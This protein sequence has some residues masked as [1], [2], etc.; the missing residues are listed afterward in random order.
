M[1]LLRNIFIVISVC[2]VAGAARGAE[3]SFTGSAFPA[4]SVGAEASTGLDGV[5][6]LNGLTGVSATFTASSAS[7]A[8]S[9]Q[10]WGNRGAAYAEDVDPALISR[11]GRRVTLSRLSADTGYTVTD[12]NRS[13]YFWVADYTAHPFDITALTPEPEQDCDRTIIRTTGSA[14]RMIY[15]SVTA[16]SYTIDRGITVS[17]STLQPD[18]DNM[19]FT[20]TAA[21]VSL[22][23]VDGT[24]NVEAPLCDTY[25][26][27][28]GDRFL[29]AWG[30][31]QEISSERFLTQAVDAIVKVEQKKRESDN[32]IKTE[33]TLGGSAPAD[34][35]FAAAVTDAAIFTQWQM[36]TDPDFIDIFYQSPDTELTYTFTEMGTTYV[37]FTCANATGTCDYFS[38]TYTVYIGESRLQC[39]N[40]FSPGP[41]EGVNDEWRV[42]YK[43]IVEFE[44]YIFNRW[45]QKLFEF[46]DPSQGWDGKQGGKVV[47][48]G[49]YYYVIK[50]RGA[51]GRDYKLSGDI[52]IIKSNVK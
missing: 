52:N 34:I 3:L 32:E 28:T 15:Y 35:T 2:F 24:L 19:T 47:P 38:D 12:G 31:E 44:C 46:H 20:Q 45:G 27:L 11:D 39:P 5:Y 1:S 7:S 29:R 13:Y 18:E 23:Y 17:Y 6:V 8:V 22:Q 49:V 40:A 41:S 33:E 36:A 25:F 9:W 42:S 26:T 14:P 50:A 21:T 30:M 48:A 10:Q 51:D 4:V 37:R 43:S 16:R